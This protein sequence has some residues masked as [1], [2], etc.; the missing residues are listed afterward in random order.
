MK[1]VI[2]AGGEGTR[3]R[4]LTCDSPKPMAR[5][6][7]RPVLEYILSLIK[8]SGIDEASMTLRYL[9]QII[10]DHF[11]DATCCGVRLEFFEENEP[12]GTAGGVKNAAKNVPDGVVVLSGDAMC[13]FDLAAAIRFHHEKNAVV[14]LVT[15]H[16]ADPREYGLV[17]AE[18]SGLIRGFVEK[19]GWAQSVTDAVNSGIYILSAEAISMIPDGVPFDFAKDL[20]PLL[21]ARNKPLYS[22]DA[23]GYWCDIGDIGAFVSCQFDMLDGKCDCALPGFKQG[24]I[25]YKDKL[26]TGNYTLLPPV[27]IGENVKIAD[28]AQVGPYA[29]VDDGCTV[30][31]GA[32]VR[33]SVLLPDAFVG[34]GCELRGAL[35]CPGASLKKR[36]A[37]FEGSVAGAGSVIGCDASVS[38]GVKIWPG[39]RV[40]DGARA[41]VN[42]KFGA[43]RKGVFDD[44]GI[45]GEVGIDLTPEICAKLGAAMGEG[46]RRGIGA[47]YDGS[48]VG[49][50]LISAASAGALST[51]AQIFDFGGCSE[52]M[53]SFAVPYLGLDL[54]VFARTA[55]GR[56]VLRIIDSHGL[57]LTRA[58]ERKIEAAVATGEI[59][60]CSADQ[61][62]T[63][64]SMTGIKAIYAARLYAQA[65][66][67]LSGMNANVRSANKEVQ[68]ML[69]EAL[70]A[71]DC[72]E[73]GIR[74]HITASGGAASLFDENG[75]YIDAA[76][77][78]A[79][80]CITA[81]ENDE[82]VALP[83]DAPRAIDVLASKYSK[84]VLRYLSCP[85]G[86]AD[87]Q[88][89][90]QAVSQPWVRD[91]LQNALRILA[92]LKAHNLKLY[93]FAASLPPFA[94]AVKAVPVSGNPGNL[95]RR[96][97]QTGAKQQSSTEGVLLSRNGGKVLLSPLK[98]GVGLRIMAEAASMEAADELCAE[99]EKKLQNNEILDIGGNNG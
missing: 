89:R 27:Y 87:K 63:P 53:F 71:L 57:T 76:R 11:E 46:M 31:S 65:P 67:G 1:A 34:E 16:V 45:T 8:K 77:V 79:L 35:V 6:C 66:E 47:A 10:K 5:L 36:A 24:A 82:D 13:D 9:P 97:S 81:F 62:S 58:Q 14:T 64:Y 51:G 20:F 75:D 42:I 23:D 83:Y 25:Y 91:G 88:A 33:N 56:A 72:G 54:G 18:P 49:A 39:K 60:R 7:G 59:G 2:M 55:G 84:K 98:R 32:T 17:V 90:T 61:Y 52:A 40:E 21:M 4:P 80:G 95:L 48:N 30:G 26:P 19:P 68:H 37:M 28:Y 73:G 93:N 22:F 85:A 12:L 94:L 3:L 44:D 43:A 99:F 41:A 74:V 70:R 96:M 69:T 92:Y 86:G 15:T 78:L 29:V 50:A 38:P